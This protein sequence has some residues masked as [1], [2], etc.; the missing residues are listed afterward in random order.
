M[1][2]GIGNDLCDI[3]RIERVLD[4][5]GARFLERT[6]TPLERER[7]DG[8]RAGRAAAF[9]AK[10][11]AAKEACAKAL[12]TGFAGGVVARDI[13]VITLESGRPILA[14]T[15]GAARA[16]AALVPPGM[17]ARLDLTMTDEYPLAAATVVASAEP[18]PAVPSLPAGLRT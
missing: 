3:R 8:L 18:D 12:G 7:A 14:L 9:L 15:G 11:F 6:F 2:L 10:R 5:F 1:I 17:R 16:L 4:R 13:G